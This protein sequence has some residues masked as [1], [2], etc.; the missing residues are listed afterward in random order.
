MTRYS[1]SA[2]LLDLD[3]P[4]RARRRV[5]SETSDSM[6]KVI[7]DARENIRDAFGNDNP[8]KI[9]ATAK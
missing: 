2:V 8:K 5:R 7:E 9:H 6:K 3:S 1:E 4:S